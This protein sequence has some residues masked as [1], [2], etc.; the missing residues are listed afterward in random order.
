[1]LQVA[2]ISESG[3]FVEFCLTISLAKL[4]INCY[5][6]FIIFLA[7]RQILDLKNYFNKFVS[8]KFPKLLDLKKPKSSCIIMSKKLTSSLLTINIK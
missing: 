2:Y 1:M 3:I 4:D 8:Y 5:Y 7:E 6:S